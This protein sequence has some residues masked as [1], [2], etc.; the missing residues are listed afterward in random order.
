MGARKGRA[1]SAGQLSRG[2]RGAVLN[3]INIFLTG[4]A[5]LQPPTL[6]R[7]PRAERLHPIEEYRGVSSWRTQGRGGEVQGML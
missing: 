4:T 1:A 2:R 7:K 5:R 6:Q 3:L